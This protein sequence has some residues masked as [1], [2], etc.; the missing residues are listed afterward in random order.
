M[1]GPL[2][3]MGFVH[4]PAPQGVALGW[5]NKGPSAQAYENALPY[6]SRLNRNT[7]FVS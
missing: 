2:G 3:R 5:V 6:G 7:T 4:L 1:I